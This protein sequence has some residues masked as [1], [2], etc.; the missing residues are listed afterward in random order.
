MIAWIE[1]ALLYIWLAAAVYLLYCW[2]KMMNN[3][4]NSLNQL[5]QSIIQLSD[6]SASVLDS[7]TGA[8]SDTMNQLTQQT[9]NPLLDEDD[10]NQNQEQDEL[11]DEIKQKLD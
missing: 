8:L 7:V 2:T 1:M 5:T 11:D 4:F 6:V 3:I 10:Q 9:F